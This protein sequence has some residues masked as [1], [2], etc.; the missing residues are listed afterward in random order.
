MN[1][2]VVV[3]KFTLGYYDMIVANV[4]GTSS[5][6]LSSKQIEMFWEVLAF[7]S[8]VP[9][10]DQTWWTRNHEKEKANSMNLP[11]K[12]SEFLEYNSRLW[13]WFW[14]I[15]KTQETILRNEHTR[16]TTEVGRSW[17]DACRVATVLPLM[18][19]WTWSDVL[20]QRGIPVQ[21]KHIGL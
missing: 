21:Q 1:Y 12:Q 20:D 5:S 18:I 11:D 2:V 10:C 15:N 17:M 7:R 3:Y 13:V 4:S 8:L 14:H 16:I 9:F 19:T 6:F